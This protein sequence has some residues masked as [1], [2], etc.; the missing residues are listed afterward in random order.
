MATISGGDDT[1]ACHLS[2]ERSAGLKRV[3][4]PTERLVLVDNQWCDWLSK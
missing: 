1:R 2:H 3:R 4:V